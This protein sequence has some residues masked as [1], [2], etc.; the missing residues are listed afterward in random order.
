MPVV[1]AHEK[2][3]R[4]TQMANLGVLIAPLTKYHGPKH[5]WITEYG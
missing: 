2:D 4:R 5:L 1:C 3:G